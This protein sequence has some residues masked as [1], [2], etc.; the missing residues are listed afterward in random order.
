MQK[1][2]LIALLLAPMICSASS[3]TYFIVQDAKQAT[4]NNH[5]LTLT[6]VEPNST[7]FTDAPDR[8]AGTLTTSQYMH[9]W[10][11]PTSYFRSKNPKTTV[12]GLILDKKNGQLHNV[13]FSATMHYSSYNPILKRLTYKIK[14]I[15]E[16]PSNLIP[17]GKV[18]LIE[19]TVTVDS[20]ENIE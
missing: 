2:V 10:D 16:M 3:K 5:V 11:N 6:G 12:R 1:I 14:N 13:F 7:W 18:Q 17:K 8:E 15:T 19:P 4:I 9:L 20:I